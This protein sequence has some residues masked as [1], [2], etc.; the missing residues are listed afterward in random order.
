MRK[1]QENKKVSYNVIAH[2]SIWNI[3]EEKANI[4]KKPMKKVIKKK[5]TIRATQR[6]K[7][8]VKILEEKV[9]NGRPIVL[10]EI[11]REAGYSPSTATHPKKV[12]WAGI[13]QKEME[14]YWLDA[15]SMQKVHQ[16]LINSKIVQ[17]MTYHK[18]IDPKTIIKKYQKEVPWFRCINVREDGEYNVFEFTLPNDANQIRALEFTYKHF[19]VKMEPDEGTR[20]IASAK[21]AG[22]IKSLADKKAL[23][24]RTPLKLWLP[25]TSSPSSN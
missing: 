9:A 8:A 12:F 16:R 13:V 24:L 22:V 4:K 21:R 19:P 15:K 10:A 17:S 2:S 18:E 25:E 6:Q 20:K 3:I 11:I 1:T 23:L 5:P 14:I 7:K